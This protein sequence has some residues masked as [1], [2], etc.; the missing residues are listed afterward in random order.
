M[1]QPGNS[2]TTSSTRSHRRGLYPV[3]KKN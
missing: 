1:K 2:C 3:E